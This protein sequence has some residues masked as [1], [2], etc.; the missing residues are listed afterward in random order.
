MF[1]FFKRF[2]RDADLLDNGGFTRFAE[3]VNDIG[4]DEELSWALM[5]ANLAIQSSIWMVYKKYQF[6][7]NFE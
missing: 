2:L 7:R 5:L 6:W 4:L 3:I 1:N